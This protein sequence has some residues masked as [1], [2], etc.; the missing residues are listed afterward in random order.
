MTVE[1]PQPRPRIR[2]TAVRGALA[3]A[4][5]AAWGALAL[6]AI[7]VLFLTSSRTVTLASH[8]AV[9]RPD[10][11]GRVVLHTGPVLPDLRV[12]SGYPVGADITLGKTEAPSTEALVER[13]ALLASQPDGVAAKVGDALREMLVDAVLRGAI[14]GLVPVLVFALVGS[15]R[16]RE[17]LR[18]AA[19]RQGA[20]A[21]L[22]AAL[23]VVG[24]WEPWD[25]DEE[26]VAAERDW[27]SLADFLGPTVAVPDEAAR[28]EVRGDVTTSQ[29]RRLI[30]SAV[31]TYARSQDFYAQAAEDAAGLELR[32]PEDGETVVTLVSDRHDNIGMDAVARAVGDAG[33]ATAVF[34]A[35]DDTSTGKTWEA[36]SLDSLTAAFDDLDERWAVTGNHDNGTF[37][38]DYLDGQGWTVLEGEPVDGPGGSRLLGVADPRSSGLGTWRDETGLSFSEVGDRLADAACAADED[39]ERVTTLL[40]HDADLGAEALARGCTDLV[41]GGHVHTQEGPTAVTAE[42]G[43]V[44]YTFTTGTTGGAAY[45]IAIG[46]KL[47]RA[48]QVTLVT[49]DD[50]RPVGLQPVILQT[51]G[52][53]D[54][55]EFLSLDDS[56]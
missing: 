36:F 16:R 46:S 9:I 56:G 53:F 26:S 30:E 7:A 20:L 28:V 3:L 48:A 21:G 10:L 43:A 14:I 42:D 38:G 19:T 54:V 50:G 51:N 40:V 6:V 23:M 55:G 27:V 15:A 35:G 31:D 11:S 41:L 32:E 4:Y 12:D 25:A 33:G 29:T 49:Y 18:L 13:Y 22:I 5:A 17:L 45:A 34:D 44:G 2:R 1:T 39:G 47:R 37:V 52:R 8:D 24:L